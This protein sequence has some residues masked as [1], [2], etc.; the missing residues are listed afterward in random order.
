MEN[1]VSRALF[2]RDA[3]ADEFPIDAQ[4]PAALRA[5]DI[6]AAQRQFG[7]RLNLLKRYEFGNLNAVGLEIGIQQRPAVAAMNDQFRH[8][9]AAFRAWS[10]RP[11]R[12]GFF[13]LD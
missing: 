5:K 2:A 10:T 6:V 3:S 9:F 12:H 8:F 4:F 13:P 11:W 1:E 7:G